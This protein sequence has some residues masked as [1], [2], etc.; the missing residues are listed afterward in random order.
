MR[1]WVLVQ[2]FVNDLD[3]CLDTKKDPDALIR[4][5]LSNLKRNQT[6]LGEEAALGSIHVTNLLPLCFITIIHV[7]DDHI[8]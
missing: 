2:N 4:L 3:N 8:L 7:A 5:F 1:R 6:C